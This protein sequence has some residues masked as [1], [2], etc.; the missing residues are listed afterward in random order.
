[1]TIT[2]E[3]GPFPY[4]PTAWAATALVARGNPPFPVVGGPSP[5][6]VFEARGAGGHEDCWLMPEIEEVNDW[7]LERVRKAFVGEFA[8]RI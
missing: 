5:A 4:Q 6:I 3:H 7:V 2:P 1:M 8:E